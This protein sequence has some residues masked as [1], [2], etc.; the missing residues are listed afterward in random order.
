MMQ[1]SAK[2]NSP[3][4]IPAA[5]LDIQVMY[6]YSFCLHHLNDG[7]EYD[8]GSLVRYMVPSIDEL[9]FIVSSG[10]VHLTAKQKHRLLESID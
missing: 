6:S 10:G 7:Y 9:I 4:R 3:K 1:H 5:M 2:L 8:S